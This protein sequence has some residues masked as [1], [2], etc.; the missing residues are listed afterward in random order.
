MMLQETGLVREAKPVSAPES[1]KLNTS[2]VRSEE[3]VVLA[4]VVEGRATIKVAPRSARLGV[5]DLETS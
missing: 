5:P 4:I 2:S 1:V 3:R